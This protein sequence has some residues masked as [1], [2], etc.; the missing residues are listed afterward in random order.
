M[1]IVSEL[2]CINCGARVPD[3][4]KNRK[5]FNARHPLLCSRIRKEAQEKRS[6]TEQLASS[7]RSVET[8]TNLIAVDGIFKERS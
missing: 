8:E 6:F 7:T 1:G 2:V 3:I 5:R 4:S